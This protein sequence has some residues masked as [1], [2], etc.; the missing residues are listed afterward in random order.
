MPQTDPEIREALKKIVTD[1]GNY[2]AAI[3]KMNMPPGYTRDDLLTYIGSCADYS[4]SGIH[5]DGSLVDVDDSETRD[6]LAC[7]RGYVTRPSL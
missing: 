4:F 3:A 2:E 7:R 5:P 6:I 1:Q